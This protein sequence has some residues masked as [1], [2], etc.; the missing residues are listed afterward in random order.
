MAD[1]ID[2]WVDLKY[3]SNEDKLISIIYYN[4]PPGKQNIGS[5]YL[6]TIKSIYNMLY[7]LKDEGYDVGELPTN[8][9]ELENLIISCGINV[10]TWAPGELEKLANRSEVTLLPVSEYTSWFNSL[11]DIVKIQVSQGPVAY[12]SFLCNCF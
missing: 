10:A 9:T 8:M 1:R 11:D 12:K 4:Y 2:S 3:I 5:S 7:T 6:D